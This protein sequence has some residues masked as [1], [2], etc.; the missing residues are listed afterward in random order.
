MKDLSLNKIREIEK[1]LVECN[2]MLLNETNM[3]LPERTGYLAAIVIAI[4]ELPSC[5]VQ[6]AIDFVKKYITVAAPKPFNP[7]PPASITADYYANK[8]SGEYTGD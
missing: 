5:S 7:N 1:R 6:Y 8:G 4:P 2:R 3:N